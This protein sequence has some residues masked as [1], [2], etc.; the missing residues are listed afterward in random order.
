MLVSGSL[1]DQFKI[2]ACASDVS[3]HFICTF[4]GENI[5]GLLLTIAA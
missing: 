2:N 5:V 3:D 1:N 4:S